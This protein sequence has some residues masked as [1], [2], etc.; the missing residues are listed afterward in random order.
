MTISLR[1]SS[2]RWPLC[3]PLLF[4]FCLVGVPISGIATATEQLPAIEVSADRHTSEAWQPAGNLS[5]INPRQITATAATHPAELLNRLPGVWISRGD[6]QEH[7]T[8]IRSPVLTG[9]GACGAFLLLENGIPV[10]PA[11]FCNVNNLFEINHEQ[12]DRIEVIRGPASALYGGNALHGVINVSSATPDLTAG[13]QLRLETAHDDFGR[14]AYSNNIANGNALWR[15]DYLGTHDA[16]W[17]D[18]A[19]Y[20][21]QKI[22]LQRSQRWRNWQ[23]TSHFAATWL[24]QETAGFVFGEDAYKQAGLRRDNFNP[25]AFRN[26]WSGRASLAMTRPWG[27]AGWL[28]LTPYWRRSRMEFLQHF[29]PEKSLE[30]NGQQSIGII[31]NAG[32]DWGRGHSWSGAL[33]VE[34]ANGYLLEVQPAPVTIP[35]A[36]LQATR[37]VGIHYDYKVE[38]LMA[39]SH[40]NI[41]WQISSRLRLITS[42]R[43]ESLRYDY[44]NRFLDG[45]SRPDGTPC[46]FGGCRFTRPA[47]RDDIFNNIGGRIGLNYSDRNNNQW[48]LSAGI[49]F[50]PPQATELYRLQSGQQV[51]DLDSETI[52]SLEMGHRGQSGPLSYQLT[53]FTMTKEDVILRD[54]TGANIS[55]GKTRH[56]GMELGLAWQVNERQQL[57]LSATQALHRYAFDSTLPGGELILDGNEVDTAPKHIASLSW[58]YDHPTGS[59]LELQGQVMGSYAIDAANTHRYAG[60]RIANL[61]SGLS[62]GPGTRLTL[63]LINLFNQDYA[64]RADFAFG[65]FRYFPGAPRQLRL[66]LQKNW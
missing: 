47:D 55:D 51:T 38:S 48:Y 52:H 4:I 5:L 44:D 2:S 11:G 42:A 10:R 37:P 14:I 36:F 13:Q 40:V 19:G 41:D 49:G 56:H 33:Q 28:S 26:A 64:E 46:G 18:Q 3:N 63:T 21:Q 32:N 31:A 60:H 12:A 30:N 59:W 39:A 65:N 61:R 16:S 50:R 54:A 45:N 17:R 23:L 20:D 53:L 27:D 29:L 35:S 25:E 34:Y 15:I 6:G 43:L 62:V 24:E 1:R 7:L 9:P 58:R 66:G 22:T 57:Q 8:A